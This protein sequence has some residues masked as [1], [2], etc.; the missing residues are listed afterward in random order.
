MQAEAQVQGPCVFRS[1]P[2]RGRAAG[3]DSQAAARGRAA[4]IQN[5]LQKSAA[6]AGPPAQMSQR[7]RTICM[8]LQPR[9]PWTGILTV[10]D[11]SQQTLLLA[12][13]QARLNV[14]RVAP[15]SRLPSAICA[16]HDLPVVRMALYVNR[17][18][19]IDPPRLY[20]HGRKCILT[21]QRCVQRNRPLA[22]ASV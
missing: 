17:I 2:Q 12:C 14:S 1:L 4:E 7:R 11:A 18:Q 20:E 3:T 6:Q 5:P 19:M 13:R 16:T 21:T 15:V 9:S 10:G 22:I 8:A